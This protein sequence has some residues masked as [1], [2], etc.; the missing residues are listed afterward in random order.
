MERILYV[1]YS[2]ERD[3]RF[4]VV[5]EILEI[6]S[7]HKVVRKRAANANATQHIKQIVHAYDVLNLFYEGTRF[8]AN[9]CNLVNNTI[10]FEYLSEDSLDAVLEEQLHNKSLDVVEKLLISYL[11]DLKSLP[12]QNIFHKTEGFLEVFGDVAISEELD[13][14]DVCNIDATLFNVAQR[15]G[16]WC[17]FDYEWTFTFPIPV[18]FLIYRVLYYFLR[19]KEQDV[20]SKLERLY[21]AY[22]IDESQRDTYVKMEEQFQIYIRGNGLN[23]NVL[24]QELLQKDIV[25]NYSLKNLRYDIEIKAKKNRILE[26]QQA[27]KSRNQHIAKL[28]EELDIARK[29]V[30]R[31]NA[32]IEELSRWGMSLDA[33]STDKKQLI[34]ALN[35]MIADRDKALECLEV[36]MKEREQLNRNLESLLM[37]RENVVKQ[38]EKRINELQIELDNRFDY[39]LL[40]QQFSELKIEHNNKLGHIE[41]LLESERQLQRQVAEKEN[42]L[43]I[44]HQSTGW[45]FLT[46]CYKVRDSLLPQGSRRRFVV[47]LAKN[48]IKK[49][50][51]Y[52]K[53]LNMQNIKKL[54]Y[55][56]ST[57]GM[58]NL[59]SR[60]DAFDEKYNATTEQV[61]EA[62][63]V[64]AR[65][66]Y[67]SLEFPIAE[68]PTVSIV[69]PVYNQF[70]YTYA[71]LKS[72]LEN[73][74]DVGYEV[75]IA[76]DVST[77]QTVEIQSIVKNIVV[78]RNEKNLRFL[79][80]CN[81]AAKYAKGKYIH[82]LNNDTQVQ[83][84]WLSSLVNLI[85]SDETIGMVGSKLVYPDGRL[86]EAGGILWNDGSAWN[87]GNGSDPNAPEFNYVKEA[88]Y[89]SG[90]SIMIRK[91]L[92]EKL[93]G[94][95]EYFA[96]AYCEDSDLAFSV[97]KV[98]YK[99]LYQ[100]Q[101]VVV[102]FEG[103]SNGTDLSSGLKAYQV[104]NSKK[105]F[106]K[107]KDVL[108]EE[109]FNNAEN[110]F[111]ARDKTRNKKCVLVVDHYVPHFDK[112]AGS[113][114][115]YQYLKLFCQAG[116]NVKF[117]GDNFYPHEP[118]TSALEQLGV[119]VLHG[120]YYANHWKD[121]VKA[122][123]KH[124]DFA[125]LNRP[126]IAV[127]Y[128]DH[129]RE[130][131]DAKIIYYGHDL[132]FLREL[133][134][135]ELSGNEALK[136]SSEEW[137]VKE[138]QLM[139]KADLAYYP[140]EVEVTE[141]H[142]LDASINVKAIPAYI[143]EVNENWTYDASTRNDL[144]FIGGFGHRPNVDA[145]VWF[146]Q[147]V[148]PLVKQKNP[149][150]KIYILGSNPPEEIKRLHQN[151]FIIK[152][153]VTD[154]ELQSFYQSCKISIVPLRYGAGI[155]GKVVEAMHYQMPVITTSVGAEGLD[156][157]GKALC[158]ADEAEVFAKKIVALY[159]NN[160]A[161]AAYSKHAL[162]YVNQH[163]T[164][165]AAMELL[166]Q[167]F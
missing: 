60:L 73:T 101:S 137:K 49:P 125:F 76:D 8:C 127:N 20:V 138:L 94:F 70:H 155:K 58:D 22:G 75:I 34:E 68:R 128:I 115:V 112:D 41:L 78:V 102:H 158:I 12:H 150:I 121:W 40:Q 35:R 139:R 109:H 53:K 140:S 100:P 17:V 122:N 98:G 157:T 36:S 72:I 71:C 74:T 136:Q 145:V 162:D 108:Q 154:E 113:K 116:Y 61:I 51:V 141:I 44:I 62:Q 79:L 29:E 55:Y 67:E 159:E 91:T 149:D 59:T 16:S 33:E 47:K 7:G 142:K 166:R 39:E 86:Q 56:A 135:Y 19:D 30:E 134:E 106:E 151:D 14:Y 10:Q 43:A 5:T 96:P 133:R 25:T 126:H 37:T 148:W 66:V 87:Y 124:I 77:D 2:N 120:S 167:D 144:M 31:L 26:L 69:I 13:A 105:F 131:T 163:Y 114:T 92:W 164:V 97:R 118:Y 45:H 129:I 42:E 21:Q 90:A 130:H 63:P 107:W 153:F 147:E 93:G 6:E 161:L 64:Q 88:D 82:F 146:Y 99:V 156:M 1:K 110:V 83:S 52:L 27:E 11:D 119:E 85:E 160:Q 89:I 143:Y 152:G 9:K 80:N 123:A 95:D 28:D 81:N 4:Q 24:Y 57:E 38:L 32:H 54:R 23:T 104:E 132:H 111:V 18:N 65:E 48:F 84:N 46:K 117:I 165:A 3:D 15:D 50:S 103:V